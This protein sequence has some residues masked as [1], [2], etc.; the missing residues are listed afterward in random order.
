MT[1]PIDDLELTK[2]RHGAIVAYRRIC[3][4]IDETQREIKDLGDHLKTIA[5]RTGEQFDPHEIVDAINGI[6]DLE[7]QLKEQTRTK[8]RTERALRDHNLEELIGLM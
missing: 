4:D 1:D 6:H 2:R 8:N 7:H 3:D 5:G